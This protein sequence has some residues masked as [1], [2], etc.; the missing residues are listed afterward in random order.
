MT[1]R[2]D[3]TAGTDQVWSA[4]R[5]P[6]AAVVFDMDGVVTDTADLHAEAWKRLFDSVLRDPRLPPDA[7]R[8]QFNPGDDYR[9]YVDGRSREDGVRA[10]LASRRVQLP[11]GAETGGS[12]AWSV[13]G[14]AKRKNEL[15]LELLAERGARVFPGTEGL[16][17]RLRDAGVP[18][19]LVTASRNAASLL[20]GA[21]IAD[22]FDVVVDGSSARSLGL[23]GKPDP[24]MFVEAAHRL[25]VPPARAVVVEDSVAGVEAG[26]R[27][28]FG[29]VAGIA[30]HENRSALE[31][32]GAHVVVED[33]SQ[34]DLGARR[35]DPWVL[36]YQGFDPAHE[37]HREALTT[38]ANGYLGTRGAAPESRA[39]GVHYPG[40]Y[41]AGVY[42]RLPN[43][44]R[45]QP[46]E[47]E[48]IVNIP[49]W[50]PVDLRIGDDG[51]WWSA[52]GF[53]T[54]DERTE[55]HLRRGLLV[56]RVRLT[57]QQGRSLHV[58]QRRLLSMTRPH[59]A[60]LTTTLVAEEWE[61]SVTLRSGID[62]CVRNSNVAEFHE[63]ANQHLTQV[64]GS[65]VGA[66]C[67]LVEAETTSSRIRIATAARTLVHDGMSGQAQYV[68]PV[69]GLHAHELTIEVPNGRPVT[70]EKTVAITT[71]RDAAIASPR[72]GALAELARAPKQFD[73]L[74]SEHEMAW[75]KLWDRFVIHVGGLGAADSL[76]L[77]LHLFHLM[78]TFT[79]HTVGLD[80]GVPARG[81]HGEGYRGHVFWDELFVLPLFTTQAPTVARALLEYR[82]RR[83]P[84]A[85]E[86]A[87]AMGLRG[88]VFPWQ[89]GS[90]G[91]EETPA[92]LY[93]PRSGRW[94]AD[95]SSRQRHVGL[96][97][98]YNAWQYY[99]A[100]ADLVWLAERGGELIIEVAR[101]FA[102]LSSYDEVADRFHLEGLMGPDE[103]HD[104][105]PDTPGSG[106]RDNAY[107]NV[108][109]AWVWARALE[110][111][112]VLR[113]QSCDE[114]MSA[115]QVSPEEPG[116]WEHLS[117]R[118]SV[119]FHDDILSQFD[120]YGDL[121]ELDWERYRS[122]YG[123]IGRLDLIL[124]AEGDST[125]RYKLA[126]QAD[127]LM[128]VYLLGADALLEQLA[129]L[130]YAVTESALARTVDYY[131]A[132]TA[133]GSTLSRVVHTAVLASFDLDRAKSL[134]A[135][136]MVADLDDTQGGTTREGV[137]L[138]AMGGT[139]ELVRRTFAGVRIARHELGMTP[140]LPPDL[141][142][143]SFR[144][145][146]QG[147]H[148]DVNVQH[149]GVRVQ[150]HDCETP[151]SLFLNVGGATLSLP[152]GE[153]ATFPAA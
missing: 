48:Q 1:P 36:V 95:N 53:L 17:H 97:V 104:G 12:D 42:N 80:A 64:Q 41:L 143:V 88:A 58:V 114:L 10:F 107:T 150:A 13:I 61:G 32:A 44:V 5:T 26:R 38:L 46:V 21:G 82:W 7:D 138:G 35:T 132:R 84:A 70:I 59:I 140:G 78:Q 62:A 91:R 86:A 147:H 33:V 47:D 103:Y 98:A 39:D 153:A 9:S 3:Q 56:R 22:L 27:G 130:G 45:G 50:L 145:H 14:L 100:S 63:L 24:A 37:G 28:G 55:L 51:E 102:A 119:P 121:A 29:L 6:Y 83:L 8:T 135:E 123:N 57:D 134:F 30:R 25:G 139:L 131:L 34:L 94:M 18:I 108:M 93:N 120:G 79:M 54:H 141:S 90:D 152:P 67:V 105:Y 43:T 109:A 106:L 85:R 129:T 142:E 99:A 92:Q 23:P 149:D 65:P 111:L 125:N 128:L 76:V 19:G 15:F 72:D 66:D 16:L 4:V 148:V 112:D 2:A 117:R 110:T 126:K 127:V 101:A 115:L 96:A 73:D 52:D 87:S 68:E 116:H 118:I 11:E 71:S 113:G 31:A 60:A 133:H 74:L 151:R 144:I 137:H 75:A 89:S 81:L 136:A 69:P 77:N 124:A 146:Y 20:A 122:V 40:S 49:N